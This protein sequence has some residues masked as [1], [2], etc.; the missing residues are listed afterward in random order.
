MNDIERWSI[1]H[2][3]KSLANPHTKRRSF[4]TVRRSQ[5]RAVLVLFARAIRHFG[6]RRKRHARLAK[7]WLS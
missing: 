3:S 4:M 1:E 2:F 6:D 7:T 5:A